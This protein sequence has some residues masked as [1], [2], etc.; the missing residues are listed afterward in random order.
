MQKSI[1]AVGDMAMSHMAGAAGAMPMLEAISACLSAINSRGD[2]SD[3][4]GSEG[5]LLISVAASQMRNP[6]SQVGY[7]V[8][9]YYQSTSKEHPKYYRV[10]W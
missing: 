7:E 8:W 2:G 4:E 6:P 1:G 3:Q 5:L 10:S 9:K